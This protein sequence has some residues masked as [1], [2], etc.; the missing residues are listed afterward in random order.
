MTRV[1][2]PI[3]T[4]KDRQEK[5]NAWLGFKPDRGMQGGVSA[6]PRSLEVPECRQDEPV[7]PGGRQAC[8]CGFY[9]P[10]LKLPRQNVLEKYPYTNHNYAF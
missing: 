2:C 7:L 6:G 9:P 10:F 8:H 4:G 5:R 1:A 3:H